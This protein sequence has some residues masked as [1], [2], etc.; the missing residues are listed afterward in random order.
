MSASRRIRIRDRSP[1]LR[2]RSAPANADVERL[3]QAAKLFGLAEGWL[4]DS[5]FQRDVGRVYYAVDVD[6]VTMFIAPVEMASYAKVFAH[7]D[8]EHE[9]LARLL[10]DFIF[11]RRRISQQ[12]PL[13]L[14]P[15]HDEELLRMGNAIGRRLLNQ[16]ELGTNQFQA[17]YKQVREASS[18]KESYNKDLVR[19]L[20]ERAPDLV[21]LLD[22]GEGPA[23]E[24]SRLVRLFQEDKLRNVERYQEHSEQWA[25]PILDGGSVETESNEY[26]KLKEAW[27]DRLN[28]S[29]PSNKPRYALEG[30]A[31]ALARLEWI[32]NKI[33]SENRR[34]VLITGSEYIFAAAEGYQSGEF[35]KLYLRHPKAFLADASFFLKVS[36]VTDVTKPDFVLLDWLNLFFPD[37]IREF[38]P[39]TSTETLIDPKV[40]DAILGQKGG[41]FASV[42]ALLRKADKEKKPLDECLKD[43]GEQVRSTAVAWN[44][45]PNLFSTD[46]GRAKKILDIL[47]HGKP[48]PP[49]LNEVEF[50]QALYNLSLDSLD[51]LYSTPA[52]IGLWS[53]KDAQF[54][55]IKGIPYLDF[56][57]DPKAQEYCDV[58]FNQLRKMSK[59]N[60]NLVAMYAELSREDSSNYLAHTVHALAY[61]AKG[62]WHA[63]ITLCRVAI[64]RSDQL[65]AIEKGSRKGREAS[66]LASVAT[67]RLMRQADD[68]KE[69]ELFLA[70]AIDRDD[71]GRHDV[72]FDSERLAIAVAKHHLI[73][74]C[75]ENIGGVP[76]LQAILS[77]LR[78]IIK[79]SD[80]KVPSGD[81]SESCH[82]WVLR[83]VFTNLFNSLFILSEDNSKDIIV[84]E[85][86]LL[87]FES[88][89]EAERHDTLARFTFEMAYALWGR[90]AKKRG[91]YAK[92]AILFELP[93]LLPYDKARQDSIRNAVRKSR[94]TELNR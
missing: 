53:Q 10:G 80:D 91:K 25:F 67:R 21:R 79:Y 92:S 7:D 62:H 85:N 41:E 31:E 81:L 35:A 28:K 50:M 88:A 75:K 2:S 45:S 51:R 8:D 56:D 69:A 23:S 30:D 77:E 1:T 42:L 6:V 37:V 71:K 57:L 38:Y 94:A 83:Q 11:F 63:A 19:L 78:E 43:W 9:L 73:H 40:L 74:Y 70:Q 27:L 64:A 20:C 68:L 33:E 13:M 93:I 5:S 24:I 17:I 84:D 48:L 26:S 86:E 61:A 47:F 46:E 58:V 32:N 76:S 44:I 54:E 60:V 12:A 65:S 82:N 15:P 3:Q 18:D 89:T 49:E 55:Y 39:N 72:R 16:I 34:L 59:L 22:E 4:R 87:K 52:W 66:Y 29:K 36:G 14:L 90:D